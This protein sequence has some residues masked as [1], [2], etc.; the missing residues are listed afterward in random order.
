[1]GIPTGGI[2]EW[3]T[4]GSPFKGQLTYTMVPILTF[5]Q[6]YLILYRYRNSD[7]YYANSSSVLTGI[8][9]WMVAD[10]TL[11]WSRLI[12]WG[13]IAFTQLFSVFGIWI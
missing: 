2:Q 8:N 1:M 5:I 7:T 13:T 6:S 10:K 12:L 3:G 4:D 11:H 9:Y